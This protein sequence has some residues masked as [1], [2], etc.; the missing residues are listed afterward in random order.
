MNNLLLA[1]IC[2]DKL[3]SWKN[4]LAGF[5][6]AVFIKQKTSSNRMI[7]LKNEVDKIK[8]KVLLL[9]LDLL[10]MDS[11]SDIST[12]R[13]LT[14]ET[15][16][17]VL[18]DEVTEDTE[19]ELLKAGIRGCCRSDIAPEN[20]NHAVMSVLQGELWIRRTLISRLLD[21]MGSTAAKNKTYRAPFGLINSLTQREY[22]IAVRVGNGQNNKQIANA[23]GITERTVK[24]HLTEI[25]LKL[26]VTDRLN[27][28]LLL[29]ADNRIDFTNSA[30]L[31]SDVLVQSRAT[32]LSRARLL[33]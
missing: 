20:L 24:A 33:A 6:R 29:A 26:G 8:P 10:E 1:G 18:I 19:W 4:G 22:D 30:G 11:L 2:Q 32:R 14:A 5:D 21:E 31:L 17:I 23:C 16:V 27:L 3:V 12:L 28:A 13:R 9:D 15:R 25:F 7:A